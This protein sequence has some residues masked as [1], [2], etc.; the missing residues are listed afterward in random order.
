MIKDRDAPKGKAIAWIVS[1]TCEFPAK[2]QRDENN[3]SWMHY[4]YK[5]DTQP[6][7]SLVDVS[8]KYLWEDE[9]SLF[10][11]WSSALK[12]NTVACID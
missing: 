2:V 3:G 11:S 7:V 8:F 1:I 9:D 12:W 5:C 4:F 10:L 6:D